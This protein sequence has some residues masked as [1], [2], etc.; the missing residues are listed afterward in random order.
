MKPCVRDH[1]RLVDDEDPVARLGRHVEGLVPQV[2]GVVDAAVAGRVELDD[3]ER[4]R[5]LR[6]QRDAGRAHPARVGSRALHAVQRAGQDPRR[7]RLA[8]AARA[9]EQVR[10]VDPAGRERGAQRLGDVL[11]PDDLGEGRR[12]VLA[13]EGERHGPRLRQPTDRPVT[14]GTAVDR[15]DRSPIAVDPE[16]KGDPRTRQSSRTLAAFRPWGG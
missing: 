12:P 4:A 8:A 14:P 7:R 13:I 10:V 5:A 2:T 9:G 11:L 16:T 1:V 3:V 15:H 6:G